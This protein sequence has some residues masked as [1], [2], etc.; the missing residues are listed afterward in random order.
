VLL[1]IADG[2]WSWILFCRRMNPTTYYNVEYAAGRTPQ[3]I[4]DELNRLDVNAD[5]PYKDACGGTFTTTNIVTASSKIVF[6]TD[7]AMSLD[8]FVKNVILRG[9]IRFPTTYSLVYAFQYSTSSSVDVDGCLAYPTVTAQQ[10]LQANGSSQAVQWGMSNQACNIYYYQLVV[11]ANCGLDTEA[12]FCGN[13]LSY[14]VRPYRALSGG[15]FSK[16]RSARSPSTKLALG[17]GLGV[18]LGAA[19]GVGFHAGKYG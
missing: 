4:C 10:W 6:R 16:S 8:G 14:T 13:V 15:V 7:A 2:S 17:I 19:P 1:F 11:V 18:G 9:T 5:K 12:V 3:S